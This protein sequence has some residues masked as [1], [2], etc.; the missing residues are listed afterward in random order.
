MIS[1]RSAISKKIA[2]ISWQADALYHRTLAFLDDAGRITADP[3]DYRAQ[4]VP[5][6]KFGKAIPLPKI[7]S[8]IQEL[9]SVGLIGLCKCS[10]G[11][12]MEYKN[13]GEFNKVR[14]DRDPQIDCK[15]PLGFHWMTG[16][17]KSC[18]SAP[19]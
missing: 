3:E 18:E 6:G 13:F 11:R 9:Y 14:Q 12:C 15:E 19:N 2:R 7:E 1:R 10:K 17:D 5:K 4:V 16:N 8:V